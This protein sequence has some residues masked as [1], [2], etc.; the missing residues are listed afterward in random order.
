M[1][2]DYLATQQL[3]L[4]AHHRRQ[5]ISGLILYFNEHLNGFSN[6]RSH[7]ILAEVLE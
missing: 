1:D 6:M 2:S 3:Q 4:H 5:L 7:E